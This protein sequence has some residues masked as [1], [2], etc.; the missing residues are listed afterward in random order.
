MGECSKKN[1]GLVSTGNISMA[2]GDIPF[3]LDGGL[4][5]M[6]LV[7]RDR[8]LL[9]VEMV[10]M[11]E[12]LVNWRSLLAGVS[13]MR[14]KNCNVPVNGKYNNIIFRLEAMMI[15][16]QKQAMCILHI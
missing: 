14:E 16:W 5:G 13:I 4:R 3:G 15:N 8:T 6:F 2:L 7:L 1:A 9:A 12:M 10:A 11:V